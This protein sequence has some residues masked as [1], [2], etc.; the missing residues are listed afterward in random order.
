MRPSFASLGPLGTSTKSSYPRAPWPLINDQSLL[1]QPR[2]G[3]QVHAVLESLEGFFDTPA[4]VVKVSEQFVRE[5]AGIQVRGQHP[6][7]PIGPHPPPSA[8]TNKG[9][10]RASTPRGPQPPHASR[11]SAE[12][13][14]Q[15]SARCTTK[16]FS[17]PSAGRCKRSHA[18]FAPARCSLALK[19]DGVVTSRRHSPGYDSSSRLALGF[20]ACAI[21]RHLSLDATLG[22]RLPIV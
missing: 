10:L 18:R 14:P 22:A 7:L 5:G 9:A 15:E 19:P 11:T 4:L 2:N 12:S 20:D 17:E 1:A 8:A 3:I 21:N 6:H 13:K 16:S